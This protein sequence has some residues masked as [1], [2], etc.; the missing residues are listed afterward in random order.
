M[1]L[2]FYIG[3]CRR[4]EL[5]CIVAK[6]T[7]ASNPV[8]AREEQILSAISSGIATKRIRLCYVNTDLCGLNS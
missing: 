7:L 1:E 8:T 5:L 2:D 6:T 3:L 4:I